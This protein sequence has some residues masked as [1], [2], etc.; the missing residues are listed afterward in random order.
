MNAQINLIIEAMKQA[1]V[2]SNET[3][4]WIRN[5]NQGPIDN[6]WQWLQYI[7]LPMR[8]QGALYKPDYLAPQ[9]SAYMNNAPDHE[10]I[11]QLVIELDSITST[12]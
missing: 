11:L 5:Y 6:I 3:P 10:K 1:G 2:W 12:I 8:L 4:D 9:L 7:H